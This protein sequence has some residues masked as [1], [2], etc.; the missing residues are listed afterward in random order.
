MARFVAGGVATLERAANALSTEHNARTYNKGSKSQYKIRVNEQVSL[1]NEQQQVVVVT[2][3]TNYF[4]VF[5]HVNIV[6]VDGPMLMMTMMMR[7]MMMMRMTLMIV[8]VVPECIVT[9]VV[10]MHVVNLN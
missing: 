9:I 3:V 4:Y 8:V 6:V 1:Y 7:L 5:V 2:Y 10:P